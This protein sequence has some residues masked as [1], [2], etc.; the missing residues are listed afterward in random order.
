MKQSFVSSPPTADRSTPFTVQSS[1]TQCEER[2]SP[3]NLP[4][5]DCPDD[6][7]VS[8]HT[9]AYADGTDETNAVIDD[10]EAACVLML[11][12]SDFKKNKKRLVSEM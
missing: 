6:A 1:I 12:T 10:R 8:S 5:D 2:I 3:V 4:R 11:F 9:Q 7:V